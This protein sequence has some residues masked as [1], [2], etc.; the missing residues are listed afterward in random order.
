[1]QVAIDRHESNKTFKR[2]LIR[3]HSYLFSSVL[4]AKEWEEITYL[5][6]K[7]KKILSKI[8]YIYTFQISIKKKY[9]ITINIL[10]LYNV[11]V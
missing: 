11:S 4:Q 9:E 7:S 1:M 3:N 8:Y 2:Q 5:K 6:N 10:F